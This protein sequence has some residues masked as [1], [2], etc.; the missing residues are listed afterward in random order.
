MVQ[1]VPGTA[2]PRSEVHGRIVALDMLPMEPVADVTFLQGD[3]RE[4]QTL[5]R[6]DKHLA[7]LGSIWWSPTWRPTSTALRSRMRR[8]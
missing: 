3:F 4:Q 8:G 6:L 5:D 2:A 1:G 7:G